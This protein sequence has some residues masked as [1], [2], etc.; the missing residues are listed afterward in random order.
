MKCLLISRNSQKLFKKQ[1]IQ[2]SKITFGLQSFPR[3]PL[4]SA[5][6]SAG[7]APPGVHEGHSLVLWPP[8]ASARLAP[9]DERSSNRDPLGDP[10]ALRR[11]SEPR[12]G[13]PLLDAGL[14]AP[15]GRGLSA[16]P[17]PPRA[18]GLGP[19]PSPPPRLERSSPT[20]RAHAAYSP[21]PP[22]PH[23]PGPGLSALGQQ[24]TPRPAPAQSAP[25]CPPASPAPARPSLDRRRT[26]RRLS[27]LNR[28]LRTWGEEPQGNPAI[29]PGAPAA[30]AIPLWPRDP[31]PG[32]EM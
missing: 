27:Y 26:L 31:H 11:P 22:R 17:P 16:R 21:R 18:S 32:M 8:P 20:S 25:D 15:T 23:P 3:P 14:S 13:P 1:Q 19:R 28:G 10:A 9:T 4:C 7:G 2:K 29:L 6:A 5:R 30:F 12:R 24:R